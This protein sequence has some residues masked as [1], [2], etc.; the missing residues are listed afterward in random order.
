M[1]I[2]VTTPYNQDILEKF[3]FPFEVLTH[4]N[5]N[6][7]HPELLAPL[8]V[9]KSKSF[10][11]SSKKLNMIVD[12][13]LQAY[14]PG[15]EMNITVTIDNNTKVEVNSIILTLLREFTLNSGCGTV[16]DHQ[17]DLVTNSY[18]GVAPKSSQ[19]STY[20]LQIPA[21]NVFPTIEFSSNCQ[22]IQAI[23]KLEV[24]AKVGG[25]HRSLRVRLPIFIGSVSYN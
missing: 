8:R 24:T 20:S 19:N 16:R 18:E 17:E 23:Y 12:I 11:M 3:E 22:H 14:V 6:E 2:E 7:V 21:D 15:Q 10:F 9:E 4:V 25:M 13:P 1:I 5:I